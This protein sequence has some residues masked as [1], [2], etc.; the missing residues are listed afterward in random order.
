MT[1]KKAIPE[2]HLN[3]KAED[4]KG[5]FSVNLRDSKNHNIKLAKRNI[6]IKVDNKEHKR[7]TNSNG[8]EAIAIKDNGTHKYICTFDGDKNYEKCKF[9]YREYVKQA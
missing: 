4:T 3:H 1:V 9:K 5:S 8:S 6:V 2:F 7:V